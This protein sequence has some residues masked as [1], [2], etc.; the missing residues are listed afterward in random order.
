[1]E[2]NRK[3][4]RVLFVIEVRQ[5]DVSK[6][7]AKDVCLD[8]MVAVL[9]FYLRKQHYTRAVSVLVLRCEQVVDLDIEVLL[10]CE[11]YTASC[12]HGA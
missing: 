1:M 8:G 4:C 7:S 6:H 9:S 3:V 10:F 2:R 12:S 5:T 11:V